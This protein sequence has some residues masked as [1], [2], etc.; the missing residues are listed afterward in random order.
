MGFL[1]V[2]YEGGFHARVRMPTPCRVLTATG[3]AIRS[4]YAWLRC[5]SGRTLDEGEMRAAMTW[6]EPARETTLLRER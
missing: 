2:D 5:P 6:S 1:V 3:S 4:A